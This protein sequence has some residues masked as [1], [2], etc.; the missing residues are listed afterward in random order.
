LRTDAVDNGIA[1]P[2]SIPGYAVAGKTGTAQIAGPVRERVQTGTD[3]RGNPVYAMQTHVTYIDG[4]IDSSFIGIMP[5]TNPQL[6]TL[7]LIHRPATW[8]RYEMAERPD[9]I[10]KDLAPEIL[11]YLAIPPDRPVDQVASR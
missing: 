3:A 5:A 10:F 8:G 9:S 1:Q 6:V 4:W 2:A 7:I 11:D